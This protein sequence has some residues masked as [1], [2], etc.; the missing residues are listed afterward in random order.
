MNKKTIFIIL[1]IVILVALIA[2]GI[3]LRKPTTAPI[4]TPITPS[5]E[6][7]EEPTETPAETPPA[8]IPGTKIPGISSCVVLDEEYCDKG[9]PIYHEGEFS[10]IGFILPKGVKIYAPAEGLYGEGSWGSAETISVYVP[11]FENGLM[12]D[13]YGAE[14]ISREEMRA[15]IEDYQK[16]PEKYGAIGSEPPTRR[17]LKKGELFGRVKGEI[18]D[19][20]NIFNENRKYT[21]IIGVSRA[22]WCS[23]GEAVPEPSALQEYFPY[24]K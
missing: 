23:E 16:N 10:L 20:G 5:E 22:N 17:K 19:T 7:A 9:E 12:F 3:I 21:L 14:P 6:A 11:P 24:I 13:F 15:T 1:G 2:I 18:I 4:E 8:E